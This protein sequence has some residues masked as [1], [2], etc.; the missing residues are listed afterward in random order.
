MPLQA[1]QKKVF[2]GMF[3]QENYLSVFIILEMM[4]DLWR[5]EP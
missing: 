5:I 4:I 1:L 2:V 3:S